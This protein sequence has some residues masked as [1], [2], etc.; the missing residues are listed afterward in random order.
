MNFTVTTKVRCPHC[1]KK[2][3]VNLDLTTPEETWLED[4]QLCKQ[5]I[6]F[7]SLLQDGSFKITAEPPARH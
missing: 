6:H 7:S 1:G 3:T 5:S 2:L 4:C